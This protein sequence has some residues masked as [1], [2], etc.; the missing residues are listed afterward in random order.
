ML[1]SMLSLGAVVSAAS[2]LLMLAP[3]VPADAT[4]CPGVQ[5]IF[6]RGTS[7]S[8]GLG[9]VGDEFY[10]DLSSVTGKS[11]TARGVVYPASMDFFNSVKDGIRDTIAVVNATVSSCPGTSIVLGGYSQGA[12]VVQYATLPDVPAPMDP[13]EFPTPLTDAAVS[14]IKAIVLFGAPR[15]PLISNLSIAPIPYVADRLRGRDVDMCAEHDP[16]CTG[17]ISLNREAH[18]AYITNGM[19]SAA[20]NRVAGMV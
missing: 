4:P 9:T 5:V 20:A 6:A 17:E 8:D 18:E 13:A 14:H 1:R 10:R 3:S 7:Q 11:V 16:V 19:V 15:N 12:A 2:S